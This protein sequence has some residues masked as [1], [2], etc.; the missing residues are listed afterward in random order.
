MQPN[1]AYLH[2]ESTSAKQLT[3]VFEDETTGVKTVKTVTLDGGKYYNLNG[4]E[5]AKPSQR[6]VYIHNG[7]KLIIHW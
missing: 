7:K 4:V 3:I 6:G 1:K 2:V 5:I